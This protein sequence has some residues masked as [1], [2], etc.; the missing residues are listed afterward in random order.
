MLTSLDALRP[1]IS[2][3]AWSL[4]EAVPSAKPFYLDSLPQEVLDAAWAMGNPYLRVEYL[5]HFLP[6]EEWYRIKPFVFDRLNSSQILPTP[7]LWSIGGNLAGCPVFAILGGAAEFTIAKGFLPL[8]DAKIDLTFPEPS[9]LGLLYRRWIAQ[10]M[11]SFAHYHAGHQFP[12][13][14]PCLEAL[15]PPQQWTPDAHKALSGLNRELEAGLI[16]LKRTVPGFAGPDEWY[17]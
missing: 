1:K 12:W 11:A 10:A 16:D 4:L 5:S 17:I 2:G 9:E 13:D 8:G 15:T 14:L 3:E 6:S 7:T